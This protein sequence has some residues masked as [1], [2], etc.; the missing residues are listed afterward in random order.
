[1][2]LI[3]TGIRKRQFNDSHRWQNNLSR[4]VKILHSSKANLILIEELVANVTSI[5]TPRSQPV[6]VNALC[7]RQCDFFIWCYVG[8]TFCVACYIVEADT[9]V[10]S[11]ADPLT[12]HRFDSSDNFNAVKP[13]IALV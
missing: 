12:M 8:V 5:S 2:I 11:P 10:K 4:T 3:R 7:R 6:V 13:N 1:M 9:R